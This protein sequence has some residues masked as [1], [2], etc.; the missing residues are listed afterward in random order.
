MHGVCTFGKQIQMLP[1]KEKRQR[2]TPY[3]NDSSFLCQKKCTGI[4]K[5]YWVQSAYRRKRNPQNNH[6]K[7]K[8]IYLINQKIKKLTVN[9]HFNRLGIGV[10]TAIN[11]IAIR[12]AI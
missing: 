9:G 12:I 7:N 5:I 8:K 6:S 2:R 4:E 3:Q 10:R 11:Q 1:L